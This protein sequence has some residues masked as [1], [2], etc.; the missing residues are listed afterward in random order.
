MNNYW[1]GIG[2]VCLFLICIILILFV[3]SQSILYFII[4]IIWFV[5][6]AI[7][8]FKEN[9]KQNN[10]VETITNPIS[11]DIEQISK[12]VSNKIIRKDIFDL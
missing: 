10:N 2:K 8:Q 6:E 4:G 12:D 9:E 5:G 3:Y 7:K 1:D 11:I